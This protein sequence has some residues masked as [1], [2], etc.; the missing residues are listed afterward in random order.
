MNQV[1]TNRVLYSAYKLAALSL[2]I[3][4]LLG[5]FFGWMKYRSQSQALLAEKQSIDN[6]KIEEELAEYHAQQRELTEQLELANT[7][8]LQY[9][10]YF[11]DSLLPTFNLLELPT[12]RISKE[13][14]LPIVEMDESTLLVDQISSDPGLFDSLRSVVN[15][16]TSDSALSELF[17][18]DYLIESHLL[19]IKGQHEN[20]TVAEKIART[21]DSFVMTRIG[22]VF[23]EVDRSVPEDSAAFIREARDLDGKVKDYISQRDQWK[24]NIEA[25][26][27]NLLKLESPEG[28]SLKEGR[29]SYLA[30]LIHT[31]IG[32]LVGTALSLLLILLHAFWTSRRFTPA[33]FESEYEIPVFFSTQSSLPK[34]LRVQAPYFDDVKQAI[35]LAD[36]LLSHRT[37]LGSSA[38]LTKVQPIIDQLNSLTIETP[39][40]ENKV[41]LERLATA[42]KP[43]WVIDLQES[44]R[45]EIATTMNT[46]RILGKQPEGVI[47]V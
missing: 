20:K 38:S 6:Q 26:E 29:I 18:V 22:E 44:N 46:L 19:T 27:N 2:I 3:I 9:Q 30:V 5:A 31:I 23:P 12:Y 43:I 13:I 33:D 4:L 37:I 47:L 16:K 39:L 35:P 24:K 42:D 25:F 8:F 10:S 21:V 7:R 34:W 40:A 36:S 32:L 28:V 14:D 15:A 17:Q 45:K 41:S 11:D 1:S